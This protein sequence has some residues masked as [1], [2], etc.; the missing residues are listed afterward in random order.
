VVQPILRKFRQIETCM[1]C[2]AKRLINVG[3]VFYNALKAVVNPMAPLFDTQAEEGDGGLTLL[4][5]RALKRVFVM[6]DRDKV[7]PPPF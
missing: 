5:I 4:C 2:S 3:E 1:R 6:N 7:P